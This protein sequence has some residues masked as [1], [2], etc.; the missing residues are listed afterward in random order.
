MIDQNDDFEE[1][2]IEFADE[3]ETPAKEPA[4]EEPVKEAPKA[5]KKAKK[6][7][8]EPKSPPPPP[9]PEPAK[10]ESHSSSAGFDEAYK[11]DK[12]AQKIIMN[13]ILWGMGMGLIPLPLIDVAAVTAVQLDMLRQLA[14]HYDVDFNKSVGKGFISSL[15][16]STIAAIGGSMIKAIPGIGSIIGGVSQAVL[17]GASTFA[18]GQ[19]AVRHFYN[20]GTFL[21]FRAEDFKDYYKEMFFKGKQV[22]EDLRN[23]KSGEKKSSGGQ[24][25]TESRRAKTP[26]SNPPKHVVDRLND[27]VKLKE[28]GILSDEEFQKMKTKLINDF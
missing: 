22:A 16:G 13:H 5:Q 11:E 8:Q 17:S 20:G 15:A 21:N 7:T 6:Q 12:V 27:L 1:L 4:A 14:D 19:V 3:E 10:E 26:S 24:R 25:T 23:K 9:E 28:K 2:D 18:V